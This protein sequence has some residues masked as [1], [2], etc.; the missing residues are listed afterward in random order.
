MTHFNMNLRQ[1][2]AL[3]QWLSR[4][5]IVLLLTV[6]CCFGWSQGA[7]AED[8]AAGKQIFDSKC[9]S[10]HAGG[11]NIV[12]PA[13]TLKAADLEKYGMNSIDVIIS[14][15]TNGKPPMPSFKGQ[16]SDED[17]Q[18]VAAYVLSQSEQGW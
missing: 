9:A 10:C 6:G 7:Q 12:N 5:A 11:N 2:P 8:L 4:M 3:R 1:Q 16:L 14:Q 17:M 15:V 18:N 13:K